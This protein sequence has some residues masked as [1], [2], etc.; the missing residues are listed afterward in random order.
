MPW[1]SLFMVGKA[2]KSHGVRSVLSSV[3]SLKKVDRWNPIRTSTKQ[4]RSWTYVHTT[5]ACTFTAL[6]VLPPPT[7]YPSLLLG[8]NHVYLSPLVYYF[9]FLLTLSCA[10]ILSCSA[11]VMY[12][13]FQ[14]LFFL[15]ISVSCNKYKPSA[16]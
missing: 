3:F 2:Q 11:Q 7:P 12:H 5:L 1:S 10:A 16:K 6:C 4:S 13:Y 9:R 8:T 14:S 15:R